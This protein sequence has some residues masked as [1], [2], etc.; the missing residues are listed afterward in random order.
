MKIK[1]IMDSGKEYVTVKFESKED[2]A[3]KLEQSPD[4]V[5]YFSVDDEEK[6]YLNAEHVSSFE[7]LD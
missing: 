7:I 6:I 4:E 2:L 3:T 1:I 5:L